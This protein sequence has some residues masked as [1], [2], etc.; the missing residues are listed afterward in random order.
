MLVDA[1][2]RGA[3]RSELAL[4]EVALQSNNVAFKFAFHGIAGPTTEAHQDDRV[5]SSH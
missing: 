3:T 4:P 2:V 1:S 5:L